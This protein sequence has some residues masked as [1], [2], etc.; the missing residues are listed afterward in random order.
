MLSAIEIVRIQ[1][2]QTRDWHQ[3]P[4]A[5]S[6]A[7]PLQI[8]DAGPETHSAAPDWLLLVA[9]QHRANFDLWH[10][11]DE[12]RAPGATDAELAAVKR[13]IDRTNQ[14][15]NDL[16]E[17][18]DRALLAWLEPSGLP[19]PDAPLHSESPGLIVD[20]LSILALKIYHTREEAQRA[21]TLPDHAARNRDRLAILE[22][23][24]SDLAGCLDRLWRETLVGTRRFKLYRQLKMYNDPALNP[25]IYRKL[26]PEPAP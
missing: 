10:I 26:A 24:R 23:Q 14:L 11:E 5:Q 7:A 20:R 9:R 17:E 2:R 13:R 1:D 6:Q 18:I 22:E 25:A 16:A 21:G 15:R 19:S 3:P 8:E 12:A 4:E